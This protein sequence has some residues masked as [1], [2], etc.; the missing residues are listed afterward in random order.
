MLI[1]ADVRRDK[2]RAMTHEEEALFGI[3]KRNM[4]G[5]SELSQPTRDGLGRSPI[6]AVHIFKDTCTTNA[7]LI[8]SIR[9]QGHRVAGR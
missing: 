5:L 2:C 1:V 4:Y 8:E 9:N 3:D 7:P 6:A